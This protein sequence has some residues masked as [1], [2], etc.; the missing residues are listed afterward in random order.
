M[1]KIFLLLLCIFCVGVQQAPAED[2]D[3]NTL[4][5]LAKSKNI[6]INEA[7]NQPYYGVSYDEIKR[8][9]KPFLLVFADFTDIPT[10]ASM[11]N[12]GYFVYNNLYHDYG[13]SAF[14]IKS[15]EN[16]ELIEKLNVKT[17]PY[18]MIANPHRNEVVPVKPALYENPK[19]LVYLLRAYLRRTR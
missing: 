7:M 8:G 9:K 12:N 14:N 13:F 16:K 2:F 19:R 18:L 10:A 11:A 17:V 5:E 4:L 15:A 6:D 1:K 3:I